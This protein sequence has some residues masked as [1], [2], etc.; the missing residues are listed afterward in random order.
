M[1]FLIDECLSLDLV[2]LASHAGHQAQHVAR[3]GKAGMD[4]PL[5]NRRL[6]SCLAYWRWQ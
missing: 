5:A 2:A 6:D 3:V 4:A 1:R